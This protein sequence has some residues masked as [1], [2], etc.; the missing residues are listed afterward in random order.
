MASKRYAATYLRIL[1]SWPHNGGV[2]EAAGR[3]CPASDPSRLPSR[4]RRFG[5]LAVAR[6]AE[7]GVWGGA[8]PQ[9]VYRA[10]R[11]VFWWF[12]VVELVGLPVGLV[13]R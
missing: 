13:Q 9:L 12:V 6:G 5:G 2:R 10:T 7:A 8:P 3:R 1:F 4:R 11:F